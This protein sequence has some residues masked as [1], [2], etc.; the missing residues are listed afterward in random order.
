[1]ASELDIDPRHF[2]DV[3]A[4]FVDYDYAYAEHKLLPTDEAGYPEDLLALAKANGAGGFDGPNADAMRGRDGHRFTNCCM[5]VEA[6]L[7]GA[8]LRTHGSAFGSRWGAG[9]HD[10]AMNNANKRFAS[11]GGFGPPRAYV[12]AGVAELLDLD[13]RLELAPG[14]IYVIQGGHHNWLIVDYDPATQLCLRLEANFGDDFKPSGARY[15]GGVGHRGWRHVGARP[16]RSWVAG[17]SARADKGASN[18]WPALRAGLLVDQA[19]AGG[20]AY[21]SIARVH[22]R[23]DGGGPWL[24]I[25]YGGADAPPTGEVA[26][27]GAWDKL[28][29]A[30]APFPIGGSRAWHDGIHLPA[31]G[32]VDVLPFAGGELVAARFP[33]RVAGGVDAGAVIVRHRFDPKALA[34]VPPAAPRR[35]GEKLLFSALVHLEGG[36]AGAQT[37]LRALC[38]TGA[39]PD[40]RVRKEAGLDVIAFDRDD[41]AHSVAATAWPSASD[42]PRPAARAIEVAGVGERFAV[43][44]GDAERH[45]GAWTM[46]KPQP[47]TAPDDA[48]VGVRSH[49]SG[50]FIELPKRWTTKALALRVDADAAQ[51]WS[52]AVLDERDDGA[53]V[54][55]AGTL[56]RVAG[57]PVCS[58]DANERN[59]LGAAGG[60]VVMTRDHAL[61]V[62]LT[63]AGAKVAGVVKLP[64]KH[65]AVAVDD[66][67][68]QTPQIRWRVCATPT[69]DER[70]TGEFGR[71]AHALFV[72]DGQRVMS[73]N[74]SHGLAGIVLGEAVPGAPLQVF[75]DATVAVVV[76]AR[77][78]CS[79]RAAEAAE[80]AGSST[81]LS[82]ATLRDDGGVS[83]TV[84]TVT[85]HVA[86]TTLLLERDGRGDLAAVPCVWLAREALDALRQELAA[87]RTHA[88]GGIRDRL[89]SGH[90]CLAVARLG[91]TGF[92]VGRDGCVCPS[93]K[94]K[95]LVLAF[96]L[97]AG[98]HGWRFIGKQELTL[99][100][101]PEGLAWPSLGLVKDAHG[102]QGALVEVV[103]GASG[104][105]FE[106]DLGIAWDRRDARLR[107]LSDAMVAGWVDVPSAV[108][109]DVKEFGCPPWHHLEQRTIGRA[110]HI[111]PATHGVHLEVFA[112]QHVLA[113]A[114]N[115]R[116]RVFGAQ[117]DA[118]PLTPAFERVIAELAAL[119]SLGA[120][121]AAARL[122]AELERGAHT[123][124]T[125]HSFCADRE[126]AAQLAELVAVHECEW[127]QPWAEHVTARDRGGP[128]HAHPPLEQAWPPDPAKLGLPTG[129]LHFYHPLRLLEWLTTGVELTVK[130]A[131][132]SADEVDATL[133]L[134]DKDI[135]VVADRRAGEVRFTMHGLLRRSL[136][137]VPASDIIA[138]L[139][140]ALLKV[141]V[142]S[143]AVKLHRGEI[144]RVS[145]CEPG[146][147]VMPASSPFAGVEPDNGFL[148]ADDTRRFGDAAA[149]VVAVSIAL[150]WAKAPPDEIELAL[151]G[152][153]FRIL[154]VDGAYVERAGGTDGRRVLVPGPALQLPAAREWPARHGTTVRV[155]VVARAAVD[156]SSKLEVTVS[157]GD[158]PETRRGEL[159]VATR[160]LGKR[161]GEHGNDVGKLQLYLARILAVGLP[162][163]RKKEP[164][165]EQWKIQ[166][167]DGGFGPGTTDALWRF[168][169]T[170]GGRSGWS[171]GFTRIACERGEHVIPA[172]GWRPSVDGDA[173]SLLEDEVK[174]VARTRGRPTVDAAMITELVRLAVL[175]NLVPAMQLEVGQP[176]VPA[177]VAAFVA[178]LDAV[179][180]ARPLPLTAVAPTQV[181]QVDVR[182]EPVGGDA[183]T[184]MVDIAYAGE[185]FALH[186]AASRSL[187]DLLTHGIALAP[188]GTIDKPDAK[189]TLVL[190]HL[191]RELARLELPATRDL[192][193]AGDGKG[194]DALLVQHWLTR[195][196]DAKRKPYLTS[197]DGNW[198]GSSRR[199]L[200]RFKSE[201]LEAT[202]DF[203]A[204]VRRLASTPPAAGATP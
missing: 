55:L 75:V 120:N 34:L 89:A 97:D 160:L 139:E 39:R 148:L 165:G 133:A 115:G 194:I 118:K 16:D 50:A 90:S 173:M 200:V 177:D 153:D 125:F 12:E 140:L 138:E 58:H 146:V 159:S 129:K 78:C 42:R 175:P 157:G 108:D 79:H 185:G 156:A 123:P 73:V 114:A 22:M 69:K 176:S 76:D 70:R 186:G 19:S 195:W 178:R 14:E 152:N 91:A 121:A 2:W 27:A 130:L 172:G 15:F 66:A 60:D 155:E 61:R 132:T 136:P 102:A 1:M 154:P 49:L 100:G 23:K 198:G 43:A 37:L 59:A 137:S 25:S 3:A 158:L 104:D 163:L 26:L 188:S 181:I 151:D 180:R 164:R 150:Q 203:A 11:D 88:G 62:E 18:S 117:H 33:A 36:A 96:D 87:A 51:H 92:A 44:L 174:A 94:A 182:A 31:D 149:N 105:Q 93:P 21:V 45:A 119:P 116:W 72:H 190:S 13:D 6:V 41:V 191:G 170:Y 179:G 71:S 82:I 80:L 135:A 52:L 184:Y 20:R 4:L 199:A 7:V 142:P 81:K 38:P 127:T 128:G 29:G 141:A 112:D 95:A 187:A 47:L 30:K 32:P 107:E 40:A 168:I 9:Q 24:P 17:V 28:L 183:N 197:V 196:Q 124:E 85:Q 171:A 126:V 111:T 8:A 113:G 103:L 101:F 144:T 53:W 166:R 109:A 86:P 54:E 48:A 46:A 167:A 99:E 67:S 202:A 201:Q 122:R 189:N 64:A 106:D 145:V 84:G 63:V 35:A 193:T 192:L 68:A 83:L 161:A 131:D 169:L 98:R 110:G 57:T 77:S 204:V 10:W 65:A 143:M 74:A 134:A 162:C 147:R 5:F 56:P